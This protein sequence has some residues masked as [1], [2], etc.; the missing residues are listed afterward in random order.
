MNIVTDLAC[1]ALVI[2]A[3]FALLKLHNHD[4]NG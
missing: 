1:A 2:V 4:P 3:I